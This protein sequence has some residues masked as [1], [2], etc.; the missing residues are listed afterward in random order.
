MNWTNWPVTKWKKWSRN[1]GCAGD[2]V[3]RWGR[4]LALARGEERGGGGGAA[5][6]SFNSSTFFWT[7]CTQDF[8]AGCDISS[9][10]FD[11]L[12]LQLF[13]IF[14]DLNCFAFKALF[15]SAL[16][17]WPH[18]LFIHTVDSRAIPMYFLSPLLCDTALYC[19]IICCH[20][21]CITS[22]II[23]EIPTSYMAPYSAPVDSNM[24]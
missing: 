9:E 6:P 18:T 22:R 11:C 10:M 12:D 13:N 19:S 16:T 14:I 21:I 7:F 15:I 2:T 1:P 24:S 8:K 5:P 23:Q 20:K 4:G 3:S 17:A